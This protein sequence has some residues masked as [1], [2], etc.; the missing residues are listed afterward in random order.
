MPCGREPAH[1]QPDLGDDDLRCGDTDPGDLIQP[2][3]RVSERGDLN[4]DPLLDLGDV[5]AQTVDVA[6]HTFQQEHVMIGDVT[7]QR[8]GQD[9]DLAAHRAA[10]QVREHPRIAFPRDQRREHRP[11][12]HPEQVADNRRQLDLGVLQGSR[13]FGSSPACVRRPATPGSGS[14]PATC[15]SVV[16]ARSWAGSSAAPRPSARLVD[17]LSDHRETTSTGSRPRIFSPERARPQGRG[18]T[19]SA[20]RGRG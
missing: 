20:E 19:S 11:T 16:A 1:V 13:S 5:S 8:L 6:Q 7:D 10:G 17:G 15:G 12:G 18:G 9:A 2:G 4:L 3:H 14:G